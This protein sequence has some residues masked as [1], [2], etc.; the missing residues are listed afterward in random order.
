QHSCELLLDAFVHAEQGSLQPQLLT[1]RTVRGIVYKQTLPP[2]LDFPNFPISELSRLIVPHAYVYQE[3]LVYVIEIPLLLPTEFQLYKIIPFP[4]S[5]PTHKERDPATQKYMFVQF[6]KINFEDL[7]ACYMANKLTYVCQDKV[8]LSNYIPGEDCEASLLHP[9]SQ[10]VPKEVCEIKMFFVGH[11][12][13]R[14]YMN[15]PRTIQELKFSIRQEITAMPEDMLENA[16]QNF[17]ERLQM[18][19]QQGR[20]LTDIIFLM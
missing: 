18:C 8:L 14:V 11:M 5:D 2:G 10:F 20:H 15:R 6:S 9:S 16:M 17:E 1:L 19:V 13:K 12:K 7:Q 3:Y 4:V